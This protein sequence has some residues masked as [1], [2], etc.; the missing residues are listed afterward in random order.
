MIH[1][2]LVPDGEGFDFEVVITGDSP[3]DKREQIIQNALSTEE[4]RRF[5]AKKIMEPINSE[6]F[7]IMRDPERRRELFS[8]E[9]SCSETIYQHTRKIK[10]GNRFFR[11]LLKILCSIAYWVLYSRLLEG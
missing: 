1:Y 7:E 10:K 8:D 2:K 11:W 4:G 9:L 3:N 6:K 5:L